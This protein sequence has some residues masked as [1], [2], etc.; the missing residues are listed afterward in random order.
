[1]KLKRFLLK[2]DKLFFNCNSPPFN[3][4]IYA[5]NSFSNWQSEMKYMKGSVL[6]VISGKHANK[7]Y[8]SIEGLEHIPSVRSFEEFLLSILPDF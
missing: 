1:M 5:W 8:Y 4:T 3:Q 2:S 6:Q 7:S